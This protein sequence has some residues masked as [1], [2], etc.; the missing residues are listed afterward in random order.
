MWPGRIKWPDLKLRF[1]KFDIAPTAHQWSELFE[2]R[3]VQQGL[4]SGA[5]T[6]RGGR[7]RPPLPV[8]WHKAPPQRQTCPFSTSVRDALTALAPLRRLPPNLARH[9]PLASSIQVSSFTPGRP[10]PHQGALLDTKALS[11]TTKRPSPHQCAL[12]HTRA[13]FSTPGRPLPQQGALLHTRAPSST[14]RRSS[15]HQGAV[16]HP[17]APSSTPGRSPPLNGA[18]LHTRALSSTQWRSPPHQGA[19]LHNMAPYSTPW[20]PIPHQGALLHSRA[21]ASVPQAPPTFR[22]RGTFL[23]TRGALRNRGA[24]L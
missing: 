2:T 12:L 4:R 18:L 11:S 8:S 17:R 20:R 1:L 3:M 7:G 22:T 15:P 10:S 21:L 9:P 13:P 23:R 6:G 14:L 19:L 16:L 5:D 24:L